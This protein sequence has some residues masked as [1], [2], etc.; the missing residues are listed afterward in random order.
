MLDGRSRFKMCTWVPYLF[1]HRIR[2]REMWDEC[3]RFKKCT[4][5]CTCLST[6]YVICVFPCHWIPPQ[7]LRF[8]EVECV[9]FYNV[10]NLSDERQ[11]GATVF[12]KKGRQPLPRRRRRHP[13]RLSGMPVRVVDTATPSSQPSP[14]SLTLLASSI[15]NKYAMRIRSALYD[16]V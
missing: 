1:E 6:R 7:H 16:Q 9:V 13:Q 4:W 12:S 10:K 14:G 2:L 5:N 3:I 11:R 15:S 8:D